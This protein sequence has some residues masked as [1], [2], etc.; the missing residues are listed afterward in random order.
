MKELAKQPIAVPI[1]EMESLENALGF[2]PYGDESNIDVTDNDEFIVPHDIRIYMLGKLAA[3]IALGGKDV[4]HASALKNIET[5]VAHEL[6]ESSLYDYQQEVVQSIKA[7][8]QY[9]EYT[10]SGEPIRAGYVKLPTATG[11]TAVYAHTVNEITKA[12]HSRGQ[13]LKT[14]ILVPGRDLVDQTVGTSS[15]KEDGDE[16]TDELMRGF[17][18]F[19]PEKNVTE[20]HGGKK[21]LSGD[22][23]VMTYQSLNSAIRENRF[24]LDVFD[25]IVGDEIHRALG[26]TTKTNIR[27]L[28]NNKI[29][30]GFSATTEYGVNKIVRNLLP[31]EIYRLELREAV[32]N[33]YLAPVR[34]IAIATSDTLTASGTGE[35][36][37]EELAK[38]IKSE[39]RN[40]TAIIIARDFVAEG[41]QGIITCL[42][43][44]NLLHAREIAER[45]LNELVVDQET[46]EVR[47]IRAQVVSGD[48]TVRQRR[49]IY[50]RYE[51]GKIDVI[52]SVDLLNEGWDSVKAKFLINLRPT[53]SQ[54][55]GVQR[56]GRILRPGQDNELATIVEFIDDIDKPGAG[57]FTFYHAMGEA[58]ICQSRIYGKAYHPQEP[59]HGTPRYKQE[60]PQEIAEL[61]ASMDH[62]I[63][64]ERIFGKFP[65]AIPSEMSINQFCEIT[66]LP[67]MRAE[68]M[69]KD[70]CLDLVWKKIPAE[71]NHT[72]RIG[73]VLNTE[74]QDALLTLAD[75]Y[76]LLTFADDSEVSVTKFAKDC[77]LGIKTVQDILEELNLESKV[78]RSEKGHTATY[79]KKEV[80][81]AIDGYLNNKYGLPLGD[82]EVSV[83][84]LASQSGLP[85][86]RIRNIFKDYF[87]GELLKRRRG[88][89]PFAALRTEEA[90]KIIDIDRS[91]KASKD[92]ISKNALA[93]LLG[94]GNALIDR[95]V[96]DLGLEL[97]NKIFKT[98]SPSPALSTEQA[99]VVA[100]HLR[101]EIRTPLAE[102]HDTSISKFARENRVS[103]PTVR[104]A[105][106]ELGIELPN[107]KFKPSHK[108]APAL[109]P[110]H[111]QALAKHLKI[112]SD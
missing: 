73:R 25:V 93:G 69:I 109:L 17:A 74:E 94:V 33:G 82:G 111:Q 76:I 57:I 58:E 72:I 21:D 26:P 18:K 20:Y 34:A 55:L 110:V 16:D 50:R 112:T 46:G 102:E 83:E 48:M 87:D 92:Y 3:G 70:L 61:I 36:S 85:H 104:K 88:A 66:G 75:E 96:E 41:Q 30:L 32:D 15:S 86:Q 97:L 37:D 54:V 95:A 19:A 105:L 103:P 108:I 12:A 2:F 23:V 107:R 71:N 51:A 5:H 28:M 89:T 29:I 67:K 68:A 10:E 49:D 60:L 39:W 11:K 35:F 65:L 7:F 53:T 84:V 42:P 90:S 106:K 56:L 9:P 44:E 4:R 8:L 98:G 52:T 6:A 1:G 40:K 47:N 45:L 99:K 79:I 63:L 62:K 31:A 59:S 13:E 80:K 101:E 38:L 27:T 91:Q 64:D 78:M 77:G 24:D 22:V 43:G 81:D 14:L 100:H